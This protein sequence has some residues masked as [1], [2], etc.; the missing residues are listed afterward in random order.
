MELELENIKITADQLE[1][2]V[3]ASEHT[4]YEMSYYFDKHTGD[5]ELLGKYIEVDPE[6]KERIEEEFGERYIRVPRIES[7]QSFEDMVEFT[8]NVRDKRMQTS[9]ERALSGGKGVFRRFKDT[10]SDDRV[11]LEQWYK[12][13]IERNRERVLKLFEDEALIKLI[14]E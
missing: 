9:L 14:I 5:V 1:E 12:F 2:L 10:L 11:L 6:L 4:S 8:E 7:W 3:F 13:Q